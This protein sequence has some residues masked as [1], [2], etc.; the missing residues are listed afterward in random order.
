MLDSTLLQDSKAFFSSLIRSL[1]MKKAGGDADRLKEIGDLSDDETLR[2]WLWAATIVG[3]PAC[4]IGLPILML[5]LGIIFSPLVMK[6]FWFF[7]KVAMAC[8][9]AIFASAAYL[10]W[11]KDSK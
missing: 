10:T 7:T 5:L 2:K 9:L 3:A 6:V 4:F 11:R 8:V 1:E